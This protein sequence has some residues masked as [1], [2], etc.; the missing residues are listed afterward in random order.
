MDSRRDIAFYYAKEAEKFRRPFRLVAAV[1]AAEDIEPWS[2]P[3][4]FA[5]AGQPKAAVS[6]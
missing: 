2:V 4:G 3:L 5:F 1:C 6:T